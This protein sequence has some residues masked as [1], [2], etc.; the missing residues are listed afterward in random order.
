M[1]A[2]PLVVK[3]KMKWVHASQICL[4]HDESFR[5]VAKK[6]AS[7]IIEGVYM[8]AGPTYETPASALCSNCW[9]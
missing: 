6:V 2:N 1:G 3:M 9:R 5:N 8:V 7:K 4:K